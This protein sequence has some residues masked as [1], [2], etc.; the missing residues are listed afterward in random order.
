[1]NNLRSKLMHVVSIIRQDVGDTDFEAVYLLLVPIRNM[2]RLMFQWNKLSGE[3]FF[4]NKAVIV[5]C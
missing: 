2:M 1:M 3:Y 4:R 5:K